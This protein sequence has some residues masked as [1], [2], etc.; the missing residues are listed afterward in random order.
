[1]TV[2]LGTDDPRPEP[3]GVIEVRGA[4]GAGDLGV[5]KVRAVAA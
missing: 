1:V 4:C 3:G 5:G 2:E